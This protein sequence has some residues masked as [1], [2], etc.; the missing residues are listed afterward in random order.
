MKLPLWL[1]AGCVP[2][3]IAAMAA[4]NANAAAPLLKTQAPG[5]YRMMVGDLEVTALLDGTSPMP[6]AMIDEPEAKTKTLM[7]NV[8]IDPP[9]ETSTNAYLVNTGGKL[10]LVD[11]GAGTLLAP[12]LGKMLLNLKASGYT[13]EQVDEV[14]LTHL[15]PDHIG[16]LMSGDKPAFPNATIYADK[17]DPDLWLSQT[18]MNAAPAEGANGQRRFRFAMTSL[19]A[20]VAA[21]KL[22]TFDGA[23]ELAPGI[24]AVPAPGH[25]P[26]HTMY[27]FE[28]KGQKILLSGDLVVSEP[29]Q[30]AEPD[31]TT[32]FDSDGKLAA[33][34]RN[35]I[36]V[37]AASKRYWF[38]GAHL[39]FPGIGHLRRE[40]K[41]YSFVPV[42]YSAL[43]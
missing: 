12:T 18:L 13:P 29:I 8:Y 25:T 22:K 15:H 4:M 11:T 2:A 10:I 30:F 7:N 27:A 37:D 26:G 43:H 41:H 17:R 1:R 23:T 38:A 9:A 14:Y 3:A 24:Q 40:G 20:Y 34:Q 32:K 39:S 33:Q 5:Y 42:A 16:G 28:S 31:V 6:A 35:K 19:N 21:G 36:Y